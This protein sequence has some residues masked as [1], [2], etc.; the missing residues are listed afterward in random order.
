[1]PI[2]DTLRTMLHQAIT[3]HPA[4]LARTQ[5]TSSEAERHHA[6]GA[7]RA[8]LR[9]IAAILGARHEPGPG[10]PV[11]S[12]APEAM[13]D[14]LDAVI[15]RAAAVDEP[16]LD[17]AQRAVH[18]AV[19]T[20]PAAAHQPAPRPMSAPMSM[21]D[22]ILGT[23]ADVAQRAGW[24]V[25]VQPQYANTGRVYITA[26]NTFTVQVELAY[27]F[28]TDACGLH[29]QGPAIEALDLHDSPP[30]Y[31]YQRAS[32]GKVLSYHALRYADGDRITA[33]LDL[34]TRALTPAAAAAQAKPAP[35][36]DR[37]Q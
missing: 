30:Q 23:I 29:L 13:V 12:T 33:M 37:P 21:Q 24:Q 35:D 4:R 18:A 15:G 16:D 22:R 6:D 14:V 32:R 1:M 3:T 34:L 10:A 31:R 26:A 20:Q 17:A 19:P 2:E 36:V 28:D 8:Y 25:S 27:H 11:S 5:P 9:S 7:Y